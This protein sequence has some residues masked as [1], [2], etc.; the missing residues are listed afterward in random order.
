MHRWLIRILFF[1][2]LT[3][4]ISAQDEPSSEETVI[5]APLPVVTVGV[6]LKHPV[7]FT[8]R[9]A[10]AVVLLD[11]LTEAPEVWSS[12]TSDVNIL[13]INTLDSPDKKSGKYTTVIRF[14]P[15]TVGT[16]TFPS[17]T[18]S[19]ETTA[20]QTEPFEFTVSEPLRSSE[21]SLA[22]TPSKLR[23][24]TGEPLR[25]DLA[26]ESGIEAAQL[27]ALKLYP[28][29]FNS[30]TIEVVIPRNTDD[31]AKQVGLP[32]GGRRVIATRILAEEET[33]VL[34]R[35]EIPLYLRFTE[36]GTYRLP[37][38]R[39]E[40][41]RLDKPGG[42][43]AR[44]AA[45]FNNALFEAVDSDQRY[46]RIYTTAPAIE[47]EVLPLPAN[48][49]G[50]E[51]SG[52]F[53]PVD[54]EVSLSPTEIE[55]GQ[56][57]SLDIKVSGKAPHGMI[58]LTELSNQPRLRERFL[59]DNDLGRI[60]HEDGTLFRTRL[61]ALSTTIQALPALQ[62]L[63]F[64]PET[65][66]YV[67]QSTTAIPLKTLP[68]AGQ[69]F[70]PLKS[71]QGAATTLTN[72]PEGIWHN[73]K[74][75]RMNDLLNA[76]FDL[77]NRHFWLFI[78]LAPLTF[79]SL[80]PVVREQRRRAKDRRYRERADAYKRFKNTAA[81]SPDK[82]PAFLDFMAAHF[83]RSG[84]AW[85]QSDS[86]EAL[87][88]IKASDQEIAHIQNL[89]AAADARD[90]ST[91]HPT[92]TFSKLDSVAK[93]VV[94]NIICVGLALLL[95]GQLVTTQAEASEWSEAEQRFTQA[96]AAPPGSDS[97]NA[98]YTQAAFKFEAAA[99][100]HQHPGEAW[101]NAGNAWFQAGSI[102]RAIAAYRIA[103]SY[104]PFDTKLAENLAAARAMTL[105]D[106]PQT[107]KWWQQIPQRW[108]SAT[109]V[110]VSV[111]FWLLLLC[112]YR[113]R[114]PQ[115]ALLTALSGLALL[116][117]T[118]A[119]LQSNFSQQLN[120]TVIGDSL[121]AKK[122]PG[123][124]YANAFNEPLHDGA[125]FIILENREAWSFVELSDGRQCWIASNQL[126][127]WRD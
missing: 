28:D 3:L 44:Y 92:A 31:E 82:W 102:G 114:S 106:I 34:G 115:I 45:H 48:E 108:L 93:R 96:Q 35:I 80:L 2:T 43:F 42:D 62:F 100:D 97:A 127:T 76:L 23:V 33:K 38:T 109:V 87:R 99:K 111:I 110:L 103:Q 75:N 74:A 55:I 101:V 84:K 72:Q 41:T 4:H 63:I 113:F 16:V 88:S 124:A 49:T 69:N 47:I 120:G 25:L 61:R 9:A 119:L 51:F 123:Y 11:E 90:F 86:L 98:L 94:K 95:S 77:L 14:L 89:H 6:E 85:T 91:Q 83:D 118:L 79:V 70:I 29:F 24:Y 20:Y 17:L 122:G 78:L 5:E 104:R 53:A 27:K 32:L 12:S 60:W 8:D 19:S 10:T 73:L 112:W 52:L 64:D 54:F 7:F 67:K 57:M 68:S 37:E 1:A 121:Y 50:T 18:L 65:G 15:R 21:M 39:L 81:D 56:I 30:S 71:Y 107:S 66:I 58:D 125:E 116:I 126:T 117:T 13:E 36:P 46:T 22:L 59:V 105:N 40:C 26:W